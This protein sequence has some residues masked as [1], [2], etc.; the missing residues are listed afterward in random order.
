MILCNFLNNKITVAQCG[1]GY[2]FKTNFTR[3]AIQ[4]EFATAMA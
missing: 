4:T 2:N 3:D 1:N